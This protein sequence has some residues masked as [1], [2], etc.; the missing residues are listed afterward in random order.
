MAKVEKDAIAYQKEQNDRTK[1][2]SV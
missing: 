2:G 1:R